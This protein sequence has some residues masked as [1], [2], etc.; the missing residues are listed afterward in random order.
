MK[1]ISLFSLLILLLLSA[2]KKDEPIIDEPLAINP[3][4]NWMPLINNITGSL[5]GQVNDEEGLPIRNA[6]VTINNET[7]T[8]N[9]YGFFYFENLL[10]NSKGSYVKVEKE[11][12]FLG[13]RRFFPQA[14]ARS[15]VQITLLNKNFNQSFSSDTES[16]MEFEGA[17]VNFPANSIATQNGDVYN[18]N[19]NFAGKWLDPSSLDV[20]S[21]MPGNLQGVNTGSQEVA[22]KTLGM[23]AVELEDDAGNELNI[24]EGFTATIS[25]PIPEELRANAPS[26][27]PLWSFDEEYGMWVEEGVASLQNGHYVG[28]VSHFSFWN[29]D[30]PSDYVNFSVTILNRDGTPLIN[31]IVVL[32][33][34]NYGSGYGF[35][36]ENGTVS[37]I[38]PANESLTITV[39][40]IGCEELL[41]EQT[42]GPFTEDTDIGL[43]SVESPDILETNISG[44][45]IDCDNNPV[46]EGI[47]ILNYNGGLYYHF[48]TSSEFNF[49]YSHCTETEFMFIS[50]VDLNNDAASVPTN[51]EPGIENNVGNIIACG[52]QNNVDY[53]R[54]NVN[55]ETRYYPIAEVLQFDTD[56]TRF[57]VDLP[58]VEIAISFHGVTAGSYGFPENTFKIVDA[59]NDWAF[60]HSWSE[61]ENMLVE[62]EVSEINGKLHGIIYGELF[63][64]YQPLQVETVVGEFLITPPE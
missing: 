40:I 49:T 55:D 8:T 57:T 38:I 1:K 29:C 31:A 61:D 52:E 44:T 9:D 34:E 19:V 7:K 24:L 25:M 46:D 35:V 12:Y 50:G 17:S 23:I 59:N 15:N 48:V 18:G 39:T 3:I 63:N 37:G 33:S 30:L 56:S 5:I 4:D 11:G 2:C 41:V 26:E 21:E 47:V 64:N 62:F 28:E 36:D 20:Y 22:L 14:N 58:N 60:L 53:F 10:M 51:I 27:I 6:T 42:I 54:L 45:L 13:S 43:I 16:L 32:F